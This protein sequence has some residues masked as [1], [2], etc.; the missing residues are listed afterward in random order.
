MCGIASGAKLRFASVC[1][2]VANVAVLLVGKLNFKFDSCCFFFRLK[3]VKIERVTQAEELK[4]S[5]KD[6]Y[7]DLEERWEDTSLS[8]HLLG[9]ETANLLS[10]SSLKDLE[11]LHHQLERKRDALREK[12]M[13]LREHLEAMYARLDL[14][15]L[16][17]QQFLHRHA[18]SRPSDIKSLEAELE[19][20]MELRKQN[21][22]KFVMN[23][24]RELEQYWNALYISEDR[25]QTMFKPYFS[26][27][28]SETL[29]ELH[30]AE[31]EKTKDYYEKAKPILELFAQHCEVWD[32]FVDMERKAN[33]PARLLA[34]GRGKGLLQEQRQRRE[35]ERKVSEL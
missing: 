7:E 17:L 19:K 28:Y 33:D 10:L 29:L 9:L 14:Q 26:T 35:I 30:E 16:Q 12:A 24:R 4:E 11:N 23:C 31:L 32:E 27:T 2:N 15:M 8:R 25:K 13:N 1:K 22:E 20:C 21:I 6:L 5:I 34:R 18:T 3:F